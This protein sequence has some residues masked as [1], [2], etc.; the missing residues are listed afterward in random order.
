MASK[1]LKKINAKLKFMHHQSRYLSCAYR[2]LLCNVLIQPQ[3][4]YG[5]SSSFPH[6][7]KNLKRTHQKANKKYIR[8]CLNF[9]PRS[10]IDPSHFRTI[11]WVPVSDTVKYCI[12]NTFFKYWNEIEPGYIHGIFKTSLCR[13]S[14]RSRLLWKTN[15]EKKAYPLRSAIWDLVVY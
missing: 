5:S 14:T 11:N 6:L 8:F 15:T 13:Y 3:L 7:K 12:A 2:K 1:V 4:D 10:H 9:P